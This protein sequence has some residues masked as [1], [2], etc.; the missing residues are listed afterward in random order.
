MDSNRAQLVQELKVVCPYAY[1]LHAKVAFVALLAGVHLWIALF[2]LVLGGA[3]CGDQRGVY[4]SASLEQQA[5]G[6]Q[7]IIDGGQNL[8]GQLVFLQ[9]VRKRKMVLSSGIRPCASSPANPR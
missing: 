6:C 8:I 5:L 7:Q 4:R 3:G 2:V 9:P 1:G